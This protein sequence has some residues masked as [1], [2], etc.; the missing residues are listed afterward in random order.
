MKKTDHSVY[1]FLPCAT[2]TNLNGNGSYWTSQRINDT[3]SRLIN[4][5][6]GYI[7][8]SVSGYSER[9]LGQSI[10]AVTNTTPTPAPKYAQKSELADVATSGSYNDLTDKPTIP[11][12]SGKEDKMVVETVAS[13]TT[14]TAAVGNYYRFTYDVGTLAIT[15]PTPTGSN[16]QSVLFFMTTGASPAVTFTSTGN[17]IYKND[18]F[19][20][21]AT[22]TY[23][24]NALWNGGAWVINAVKYTT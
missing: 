22:T 15:L 23:E 21:D 2:R 1:V 9:Y 8:V 14:L 20:I 10:R 12:I 5:Y 19:A 13:G 4:F 17:T 7:N 16:A 18:G 24:I 6:Q 3:L 11:D